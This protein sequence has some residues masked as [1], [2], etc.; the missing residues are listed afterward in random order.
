M[1]QIYKSLFALAAIAFLAVAPASAGDLDVTGAVT[2]PLHL[3]PEAL[4]AL[5]ASEVVFS[6]KQPGTYKGVLL[7]VLLDKAEV[8]NK[9]GKNTYLQHTLMVIASDGYA[10]ALAMGEIDPN[11]E[12]KSVILAYDIDGKKLRD[13][14][15]LVVPGEK[16]GGRQVHDVVK[17]EVQ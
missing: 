8:K 12:A 11:Y 17:I 2:T 4:R 14:Y 5:P 9:S 16:E 6:G 10:A 7:T 13:G 15:R 1:R 3:S